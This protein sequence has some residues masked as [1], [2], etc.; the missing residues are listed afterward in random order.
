[1]AKCLPSE[2]VIRVPAAGVRP[3]IATLFVVVPNLVSRTAFLDASS[4]MAPDV[5]LTTG[6]VLVQ[7]VGP[8]LAVE[9]GTGAGRA[10]ACCRTDSQVHS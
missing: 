4:A 9:D 7:T 2:N 1:L 5:F 8:A 10:Q 3:P 6:A